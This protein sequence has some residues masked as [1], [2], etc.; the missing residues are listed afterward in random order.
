MFYMRYLIFILLIPAIGFAQ[1]SEPVAVNVLY[2]F[3]H[4]TDTADRQ[5][6]I[7]EDMLLQVGATTSKY[8]RAKSRYRSA[9][10]PQ[11]A[12][13]NAPQQ[14]VVGKPMAIVNDPGIND[15]EW[16]QFPST[17]KLHLLA[18]LGLQEY[19]MELP[20]PKIDW[21]ITEESKM[22]GGYS[23]QKA[24]GRFAGRDYTAW[25]CA[26]LP[27]RSGPWKLSGLPGLILEAQ[28]AKQ[29]V[30]FIFKE[31][32]KDTTGAETASLRRKPVKV[33]ETAYKRAKEAFYDNP[34]AA[35]QAQLSPGTAKVELLYRDAAGKSH[36]G[37]EAERLL[38]SNRKKLQNGVNNPIELQR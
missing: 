5:S 31:I 8:M 14:V 26:A 33:S 34:A 20:L 30:S 37:E 29:E 3:V 4:I 7:S 10:A 25:F 35:M 27:F 18:S 32:S 28:D 9:P 1:Q 22:I 2:H 17:G 15:V 21:R 24:V 6:P 19:Q 11:P 16:L 38:N 36:R 12:V 23:C 13:S